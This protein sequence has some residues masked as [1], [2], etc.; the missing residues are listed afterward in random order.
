MKRSLIL[1]AATVLTAISG[2]GSQPERGYRGFAEWTNR[3]YHKSYAGDSNTYYNPGVATSHGYQFNPWIFAG[4]GVDYSLED[5]GQHYHKD[6]LRRHS[7]HLDSY[8]LAI[9]GQIRTDLLFGKFTPFADIRLGWN[10]SSS[11]TVYFSPSIGYRFNWGRKAGL[12]V[13][14]GYTLDGFR[15]ERYKMVTTDY[16]YQT[17]IPTG[18]YYNYALSSFS[19]RIG[20]DF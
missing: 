13:G 5:T 19:F 4:A 20:I 9:F 3:I 11:G 17:S 14:V 2:F 16:G 10:A 8:F 18:E 6:H 7:Y 15:Y 12:N 1:W